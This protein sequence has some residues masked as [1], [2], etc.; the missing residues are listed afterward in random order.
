MFTLCCTL[1]KRS[2]A[3]GFTTYLCRICIVCS[4]QQPGKIPVGIRIVLNSR[5]NQAK[6]G[7]AAK[8][9]ILRSAV[10]ELIVQVEILFF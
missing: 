3:T 6:D 10:L 7:C 1:P 4:L 8:G 9:L 2:N 5:L